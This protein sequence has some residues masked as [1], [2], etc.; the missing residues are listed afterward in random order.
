M[1]AVSEQPIYLDYNATTP[2]APEV[3][4]AMLPVLRDG[5]GN[6][7]SSHAY[8]NAARAWVGRAREQV[9]ALLDC[10]PGEVIFT[11]GG[12]E[13]NNAA[14]IGI[15]EATRDKGRHLVTSAIEHPAVAATCDYLEGRGWEVTRLGV[16]HD[17]RIRLDELAR[18]VRP[19]TTL[20]S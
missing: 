7:S 4:D 11:S 2:I 1:P 19:E 18:A 17:G 20:I 3:L 14:L 15:A 6:P 16:D 5:F 13:S 9:A 10:S 12:T 8:G